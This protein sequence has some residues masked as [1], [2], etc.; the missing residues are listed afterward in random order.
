MVRW[1]RSDLLSYRWIDTPLEQGDMITVRVKDID[2]N[3][4]YISK[5][6]HSQA[7]VPKPIPPEEM[8]EVNKS[9]L[10]YFYRLELKLKDGGIDVDKL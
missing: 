10:E 1:I 3:S 8:D 5:M 6:P 4:D 7:V 9:R 2:K